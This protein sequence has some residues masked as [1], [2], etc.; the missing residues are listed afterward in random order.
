MSAQKLANR[1]AQSQD[2]H[3]AN[4]VNRTGGVSD[5]VSALITAM[6]GLMESG[7]AE[8]ALKYFTQL[9]QCEEVRRAFHHPDN[10]N[11]SVTHAA[12]ILSLSR[13]TVH[14]KMIELG[15]TKQD[16]QRSQSLLE[17]MSASKTLCQ[18]E[19]ELQVILRDME[20]MS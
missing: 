1:L 17:L 15:L 8:K 3:D 18:T 12:S 2:P 5:E 10:L 9:H 7:S 13:E 20:G 11:R 16:F 6:A 19:Q 14:K 4:E